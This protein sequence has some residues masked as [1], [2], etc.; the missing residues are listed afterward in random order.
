V[1]FVTVLHPRGDIERP[2]G[3]TITRASVWIEQE[4]AI[5]AYIQ[6]IEKRQLPVIVFKHK[7]VGL[8]GLRALL[9]LNPIEFSVESEVL[10]SLPEHVGKW[11]VFTFKPRGSTLHDLIKVIIAPV[12]RS[13]S[14]GECPL[15]KLDDIGVLIRL[16]NGIHVRIPKADYI[17][18]WDDD[19]SKPKLILTRKYFQGHLP[20][21]EDAAEFFLPAR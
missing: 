5:A 3:P 6:R 20:G 8:E 9:H 18:S 7:N 4:I 14:E 1:G 2:D 11:P 19:L 17:E 15:E 21:Y 12:S 13:R 16:H 10:A